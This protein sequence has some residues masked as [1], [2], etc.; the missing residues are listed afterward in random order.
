[1][2]NF[3]SSPGEIAHKLDVLREHCKWE[4]TDYDRTEKTMMFAG[5]PSPEDPGAFIVAM[6]PYAEIGIGR[7]ILLPSAPTPLGSSGAWASG[8]CPAVAAWDRDAAGQRGR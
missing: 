6:G 1:M 5:L 4:G 3:Y 2:C 7:I 8:R